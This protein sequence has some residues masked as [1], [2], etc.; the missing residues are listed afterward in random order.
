MNVNRGPFNHWGRRSS[1]AVASGRRGVAFVKQCGL[2]L[3]FRGKTAALALKGCS[4]AIGT[5][6]CGGLYCADSR[7]VVWKESY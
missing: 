3:C 7:S 2:D 1:I 6:L 5:T 4:L